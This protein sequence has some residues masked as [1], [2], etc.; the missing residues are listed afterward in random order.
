[1]KSKHYFTVIV[2]VLIFF[3]LCVGVQAEITR[4]QLNV[5]TNNTSSGVTLRAWVEFSDSILKHPPDAF[6]E[7]K[8]IA[9]DGSVFYMT[10]EDNWLPYDFGFHAVYEPL[11]FKKGRIPSGFYRLIVRDNDGKSHYSD[12]YLRVKILKLPVITKPVDGETLSNLSTIKWTKVYG[13]KYYRIQLW[14]ESWNEPVYW[15]WNRQARTNKTYFEIPEGTLKPGSEY[16]LSVQ[17]RSDHQDL[18]N[19]SNS[20]WI[21]FY[22][23]N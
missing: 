23:Q 9:P 6:T 22:F 14:N 3:L 15:W 12:D 13:A 10:T 2:S 4:A 21:I 18:E 8:I 20:D 17:A 16:R 5:W 1:M 11:D 19:R 7:I